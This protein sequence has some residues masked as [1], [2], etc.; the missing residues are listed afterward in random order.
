MEQTKWPL[1]GATVIAITAFAPI[2]LSSDASGEFAGS[3]FWVL[4][5]SLLL[6]WITA[7]TLT[8]FFADLMFKETELKQQSHDEDPYQGVIF[9]LYKSLLSTSMRFRKTTLL[10]MVVLLASSVFGFKFIKQAFFPASNTPMFYVDYWHTQGADIHATLDGVAKL[11][12]F[13]QKDELVEEVT[14]TI[15]Q[16]APRF[17][18]TYAPEKSY[19]AYGQLIIRVKD[20]E[21][22]ATMIAKVRDYEYNH[23]FDAKLKIKRMEIVPSTDAKIEA[24]FSVADPVLL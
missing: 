15:G 10:L 19:P 3:L 9:N 16:G 2:G 1:L 21:A 14:S 12:A 13:L 4:F 17:M 23:V 22:V 24:R 8:P 5:I 7:I 18:L 11:E 20:R 6:S